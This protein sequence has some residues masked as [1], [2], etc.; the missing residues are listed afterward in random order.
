MAL[1]NCRSCG[2][3]ISENA[4]SCPH[5]GEPLAKQGKSFGCGT[6]LLVVAAAFFLFVFVGVYYGSENAEP[7]D[8]N[9]DSMAWIMAQDFIEKRLSSPSTAEFP[10]YY[11]L[12]DNAIRKTGDNYIIDAYVDSQ[13]G[14]GA[15]IRTNFIVNVRYS[16]DE[17]W[18]L[19]NLE[20]DK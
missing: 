8:S 15:T 6:V 16:G 9:N 5:C 13:N 14:F 4:A 17:T 3:E 12:P 10:R 18:K 20:F 1:L 2:K 7:Y 19:I 11:Q